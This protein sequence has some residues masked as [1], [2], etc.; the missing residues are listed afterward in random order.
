MHSQMYDNRIVNA[1]QN[2]MNILTSQRSQIA[3]LVA[4][5]NALEGGESKYSG[6]VQVELQEHTDPASI[7]ADHKDKVNYNCAFCILLYRQ[8]SE[9]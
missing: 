2:A 5:V 6:R 4:R 7:G 8:T 9:K 1:L 3:D